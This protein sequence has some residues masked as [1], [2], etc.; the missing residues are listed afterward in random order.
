MLQFE[1]YHVHSCYSNALTQPDSTVFISDY[2]KTYRERGHKV[3]CM[4][5]HGNRSNVWEQFDIAEAYKNDKNNPYTLTPLAAAEVYF[6]PN[7]LPD[8]DGKKDGRNFH[9]ILVA[10]NMEGFYQ[11][12]EILSEA[13]LSGYYYH[14]RVDFDLL[15]RLNYKNFMCTTA[16]VAGI[17]KDENFERLACQL[18]E[19]FRENFYLEVQHHPQQIQKETNMKI[20]RLYQK[21]R[22]PLIYG[23]DSHYINKEDKILRTELMLS[24]G[25][26]YGDE[27]SFDLYLPTAQEAYNLL[28]NQGILTK[29]KIE[30][31]MEN[32]LI[33]REFEGVNFTKE[34]KIPNAFPDM[35]LEERNKLYKTT[36]ID[37]YTRKAG[38]PTETERKELEDEMNAVADTGTADYFL[39]CKR[40][41]DRGR[42]L[43]G[44][45]TK[46]G[47]GSGSSFAT[48][49]SLGF[50]SLNRLHSPVKLYP[51]RFIS[52]ERMA[53]GILPDLDINL[54]N[55][56]AFES[57]GQEILGEYGCLPMINY[58]TT[59]TLSAFKML[60]KARDL[61]FTLA[62]EVSKQIKAYELDV[63]HAVENNVDD[64]D[65]N[66]DDDVQIDSYV[67]EQYLD[68]IDDS[69]KYQGIVLSL[70]P[71]PCAHLLLDKDIRREIGVVRIKGD[72]IVAY[73]DGATADAYGYL[74]LDLLRVTVVE[75]I[76]KT[77]KRINLPVMDVDELL[78]RVKND[79]NVW[80]L[81]AKGYTQGLNQCEQEK[82]TQRIMRYKPRNIVELAA[83]V[84]AIRPGFKSMLETFISRTPFK[85]N[86][87]ALDDLLRSKEIEDSFLLYDEQVLSILISA[88]IKASD[89]YVCLKGIKKKK[90]D[91]VEA[92]KEEF[93]KGYAAYLKETEHA[94]DEE[95][96]KIVDN[97]WGIIESSA[98]YLFNASHSLCMACDSLYVAWL[99]AYYP[100][101]LYATMLQIF[102]E[103]KNKDK[104]ANIISEMKRYKD[105]QITPGKFGQ[106]N[107]DWL[108]DKENHMISQNLASIRYMSPQVAEDLYNLSKQNEVYIGSEL[109][110]DTF[111]PEAKKEIAKLKK[112]LKPLQEKAEAY[113]AN[114]GDEFDGE[115]LAMYD[116]GYPLEQEIKRIESDNSS[117]LTRGGEVKHYVKLDCFTNILRAIQMNTCLDTRQIE[118]LIGLNYFE[119][120]GKT[121]KLMKVF[122][123]FFAGDKKLTKQIKSFEE[124]LTL[125]RQYENSLDDSDLPA[126]LRLRYEMDNIGL[127][128]FT[129]SDALTNVYF[130]TS[131]DDKY[132]IKLN[133]YNIRR[134]TTGIVKV[135][136]K[137]YHLV[138]EG[139][140]IKIESYRKSPKYTYNKGVKSIVPGETEIWVTNYKVIQKGEANIM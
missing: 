39:L 29:A 105:I 136:K 96:Q 111:T 71:H 106:D 2:A 60:A 43:G 6:V 127:C 110:T 53:A 139:S 81:Y 116:E 121:E 78:K 130:V 72:K 47:R 102:S 101:E 33:L 57:A 75:I 44:I 97:I 11:L 79:S 104:I 124:R 95:A 137:D 76:A 94:T 68:L 88:A 49:F 45:I 74:K 25:I 64:P 70:G 67:E 77:F 32:T 117:Y 16:C 69:K 22:W 38:A 40:I 98:S 46:T 37:E 108:I 41:V 87:P 34:K 80:N 89:A 28:E 129:N 58:G 118:I 8:A 20:L 10:K 122:N 99:K 51:E 91:K 84:A 135:A 125:C 62:N 107:R 114:G 35:S 63:K 14:A 5:E 18:G 140:C 42:E 24:K 132:S 54:T 4:S 123:E 90:F 65:Y 103:K 92:F 7:R 73:I 112:K 26:S 15:G 119:Q 133:L 52:K 113:L 93:R 131:I 66:V 50:T 86:I 85:Y 9:L 21:Y 17:T 19:I 109:K 126:G 100:Y 48:N 56:E 55:V 120:F 1:P 134:G 138:G 128:L 82:A 36:C 27:D 23:T 61:D 31:A 83:F 13:N 3:L 59:K 12:N 115:F 30:E